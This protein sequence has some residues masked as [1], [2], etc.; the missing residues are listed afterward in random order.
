M[1]M[2]YFKF[3]KPRGFHYQ[4]RYWNPDQEA[5]QAREARIRRQLGIE[6]PSAPNERNIESNIKGAFRS[7]STHSRRRE[8]NKDSS[9]NH[10]LIIALILL[11][12]AA[13]F[14]FFY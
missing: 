6:D 13:Y 3:R 2:L 9:T 10:V 11:L 4:P 14:I 5:K 8:D 12:I 7:K 1:A